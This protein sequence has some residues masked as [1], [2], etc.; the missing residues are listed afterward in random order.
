MRAIKSLIVMAA[1]MLLA[2]SFAAHAQLAT[3]P[4]LKAPSA[5]LA[6]KGPIKLDP[7]APIA[8]LPPAAT[9]DSLDQAYD[10]F[11]RAHD[12]NVAA[13]NTYAEARTAC[14][15]RSFS[16][17]DQR[18]AGCMSSDT[19]ATCNLKLGM[20]CTRAPFHQLRISSRQVL[21]AANSLKEAIDAYAT[22]TPAP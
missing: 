21:N 4:A 17:D 19:V 1:T 18:Q 20:W 12:S 14:M 11:R 16:V 6:L 15:T 5:N 2:G 8:N 3:T 13:R 10:R 7:S 22:G 9:R